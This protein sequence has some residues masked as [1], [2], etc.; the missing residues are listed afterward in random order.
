MAAKLALIDKDLLLRLLASQKTA[1]EPPL[2]PSDPI[3]N[4]MR[5]IDDRLQSVLD[6]QNLP[7]PPKSQKINDLI[8]EHDNF[9]QK[10]KQQTEAPY[11]SSPISQ[12][13]SPMS[14]T[15]TGM[16]QGHEIWYN[17]TMQ[18]A[19]KTGAPI[20]KLLLDHIKSS[21]K[22]KWDSD[23]RLVVDGNPIEGSNIA[24]LVASVTKKRKN[25]NPPRGA[26]IFLKALSDINTPREA[27]PHIESVQNAIGSLPTSRPSRWSNWVGE[28]ALSR[29]ASSLLSTPSRSR[30]RGDTSSRE[31]PLRRRGDTS[32]R[33]SLF[34]TPLSS[35]AGSRKKKVKEKEMEHPELTPEWG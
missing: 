10:Y 9:Y 32:S 26:D 18:L 16:P 35:T 5:D 19:T 4:H 27:A 15:A 11:G 31:S 8:A 30:R 7:P 14:S 25:V 2:P 6:S 20:T 34:E 23:G 13:Q 29:G 22:V 21:N 28:G 17:K 24:D 33:E 1:P 3:L 12:P